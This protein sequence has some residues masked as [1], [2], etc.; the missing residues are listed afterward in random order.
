VV[1]RVSNLCVERVSP[2]GWSWNGK[3][4]CHPFFQ[5]GCLHSGL[6]DGHI[7][8]NCGF[9]MPPT[10][11]LSDSIRSTF[12]RYL[13]LSYKQAQEVLHSLLH[14]FGHSRRHGRRML[15]FWLMDQA[16]RGTRTW[17]TNIFKP[18]FSAQPTSAL[19]PKTGNS[20][21]GGPRIELLQRFRLIYAYELL[22][23]KKNSVARI[24]HREMISCYHQC[25][26]T[27]GPS[28]L[29]Y[30]QLCWKSGSNLKYGTDVW[31]IITFRFPFDQL[32]IGSSKSS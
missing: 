10:Y 14:S 32:I 4:W 5:P 27:G 31:T 7:L 20:L 30:K 19:L 11:F 15:L 29:Q 16:W 2:P 17:P 3:D 23:S 9:K 25:I 22:K 28:E 21:L 26:S 1:N 24:G 13:K 6:G 18:R 8:R 12:S